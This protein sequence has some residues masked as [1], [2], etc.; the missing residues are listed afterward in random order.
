MTEEDVTRE[1]LAVLSAASILPRL[2]VL[3]L[4]YT[5]WPFYWKKVDSQIVIQIWIDLG[6]QT[7]T[8]HECCTKR[9]SPYLYPQAKGILNALKEKE[10]KLAVASRTPTPDIAQVFLTKLG[11]TDFFVDMEIFPS[12]THKTEH[13]ENIHQKTK[14]P[15]SSVIFFDDEDR[16]IQSVSRMGVTSVL[17]HDGVD[18][19]AL[20]KGLTD[21]AI[22]KHRTT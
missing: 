6:T 7:N 16:N 21:F 8:N 22:S 12:W 15:F 17:V 11:L 18:I 10:V 2:V 19:R 9:D 13:L 5:L 4:D 14:I 20:Q 1:A 3:D